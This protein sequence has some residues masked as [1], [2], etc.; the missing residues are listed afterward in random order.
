MKTYQNK[1]TNGRQTFHNFDGPSGLCVPAEVAQ[2]LLEALE[3]ALPF[4]G[5]EHWNCEDIKD[6]ARAAIKAAI[7]ETEWR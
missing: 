1:P 2:E 5:Y 3:E 6:K 4:I 7:K